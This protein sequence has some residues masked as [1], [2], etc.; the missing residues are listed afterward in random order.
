MTSGLLYG[1]HLVQYHFWIIF[2]VSILNDSYNRLKYVFEQIIFIAAIE[3]IYFAIKINKNIKFYFAWEDL[4]HSCT[5]SLKWRQ[6]QEG[7]SK[8]PKEI[9]AII[10]MMISLSKLNSWI[11]YHSM[12]DLAFDHV[13]SLIIDVKPNER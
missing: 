7:V 10:F 2:R 12:L 1:K 11:I 13:N 5:V 8:I 9:Y 4:V 3:S 6:Y